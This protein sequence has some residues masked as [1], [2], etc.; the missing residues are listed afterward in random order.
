M[1]Q[2][3]LSIDLEAIIK[4]NRLKKKDNNRVVQSSAAV[5]FNIGYKMVELAM[6]SMLHSMH[7]YEFKSM[8]KYGSLIDYANALLDGGL[9]E[10][11]MYEKIMF[12]EVMKQKQQLENL[13]S[14]SLDKE[15]NKALID[16]DS[17][18]NGIKTNFSASQNTRAI[19]V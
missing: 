11:K 5:A 6:V 9:I 14:E 10:V 4:A 17:V 15:I 7:D 16:I 8:K 19:A 13:S 18:L 3:E 1:E 12:I 2:A